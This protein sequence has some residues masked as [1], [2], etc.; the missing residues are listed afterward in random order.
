VFNA[1]VSERMVLG[2]LAPIEYRWAEGNYERLSQMAL[3]SG[4]P[5]SIRDRRSEDSIRPFREGG[6]VDHPNRV[7][8]GV[9]PVA[10]GLASSLARP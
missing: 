1:R 9:D 2:G 8:H 10:S 4:P 3:E 5:G 7:S 6:H